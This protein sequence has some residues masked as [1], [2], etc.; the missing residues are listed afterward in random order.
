MCTFFEIFQFVSCF[1]RI[2]ALPFFDEFNFLWFL[3]CWWTKL[4]CTF[5]KRGSGYPTLW[6]IFAHSFVYANAFLGSILFWP[7]SVFYD[8]QLQI[9]CCYIALLCKKIARAP[10]GHKKFMLTKLWGPKQ[11][12]SHFSWIKKHI[13]YLQ[14]PYLSMGFQFIWSQNNAY[15]FLLALVQ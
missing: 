6:L 13:K 4:D 11:N 5:S 3:F 1:E 15:T 14:A 7:P 8:P 12:R 10:G 9:I 2:H